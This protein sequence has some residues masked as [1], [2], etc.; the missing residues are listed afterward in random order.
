MATEH[1]ED[2]SPR[3]VQFTFKAPSNRRVSGIA[4]STHH[5]THIPISHPFYLSSAAELS[6]SSQSNSSVDAILLT[7]NSHYYSSDT[8]VTLPI[9]AILHGY[10]H[11]DHIPHNRLP[12]D[13]EDKSME[14]P[15]SRSKPLTRL[16]LDIPKLMM[17]NANHVTTYTASQRLAMNANVCLPFDEIPFDAILSMMMRGIFSFCFSF[18]H[19]GCF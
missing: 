11:M 1:K 4:G 18:I 3:H 15:T 2:L 7:D 6:I 17:S 14:S 19:S 9:P 16:D 8:T 13:K 10:N 12:P 5:C